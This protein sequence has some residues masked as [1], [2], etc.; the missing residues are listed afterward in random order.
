M[1]KNMVEAIMGAVVLLVAGVFVSFAFNTAQVKIADGYIVKASFYKIGG[2]QKGNDVRMRGIKVG[3]VLDRYLDPTTF[4]AVVEMSIDSNIRIPQDTLASISSEGIM[5]G[6]YVQLDPGQASE[7][8]QANGV[9]SKTHD[10]RSLED[11]VGEIIFLASGG[12]EKVASPN[13]EK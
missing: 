4:D 13:E 9:I 2:L 6:K 3:T 11:Q 5:G 8:I 10:Y 1:Q 12:E 7:S